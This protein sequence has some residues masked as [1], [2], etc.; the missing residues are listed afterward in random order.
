MTAFQ[1]EG[2]G[3]G[4]AADFIKKGRGWR[5]RL[6]RRVVKEKVLRIDRPNG[7]RVLKFDGP[8]ARGLWWRLRRKFIKVSVTGLAFCVIHDKHSADWLATL[9]SPYP[10]A[11]DFPP[12]G[13]QNKSLYAFL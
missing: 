1:A 5:R 9:A 10:A 8:L 11:P 7:R 2:C 13:E 12:S 3:G 4:F 6:C